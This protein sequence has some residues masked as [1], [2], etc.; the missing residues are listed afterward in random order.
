MSARALPVSALA[1]YGAFGF[2]LAAA[3]LPVYVHLPNLYGGV[4]G[5]N[6]ALLG[7]VLLALRLADAFADPLLGSLNDR[8]QRPRLLVTL[9]ALLLAVGVLAVFHPPRHLAPALWLVVALLPVYLGYSLASAGYLAWGA[10][11]GDDAHQRTRVAASREAFGLAGVVLA[12]VAP[13]LLA[14]SLDA[15]LARY[16]LL[17][18]PLIALFAGVTVVRAPAPPRLPAQPA[19][20]RAL[21]APFA[22]PAFTPL[23]VVFVLNGIAAA[24]P[25]TLV[26]FF[27]DDALGV[28]RQAGAF[29]AAYFLAGAAS[30]PLWVRAA[31]RFGKVTAWRTSMLVAVGAFAGCFALGPGDSAGF[32]AVCVASGAA[33]GAD[34]ALPPALLADAIRERG[35]DARAGSYFGIWNFAAKTNLALAAGL[36]LP[37]LAWLGYQPGDSAS[38]APLYYAYC[39]LPCTLKLTAAALLRRGSHALP[40]IRHA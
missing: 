1:A 35:D 28:P 12:S 4:L 34:L 33:L 9:G 38:V 3:A 25:A 17:A 24:L 37:L 8:L 2:P 26:L 6:L 27:V 20:W 13:T 19:G 39:V 15:G 32:L 22:N 21:A 30:L 40:E 7:G 29:L 11:L 18:A 14:P 31:G 10:L 36:A 5:M 16:A 23:L